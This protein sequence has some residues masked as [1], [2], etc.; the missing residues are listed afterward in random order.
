MLVRVIL[1]FRK[2]AIM[3]KKRKFGLGLSFIF[4]IGL[5]VGIILTSQLNTTTPLNATTANPEIKS[6]LDQ[7]S[8]LTSQQDDF[9]SQLNG[10][11]TRAAKKI[12]PS[13]VTIFSKKTIKTR[14][15]TNP[16]DL[17]EEFFRG[18]RRQQPN[19]QEFVRRGMGSGVIIDADGLILTNNHV[20][21]DAD[22]ISVK[23]TDGKIYDAEIIGTDPNT[24]LAVI[25]IDVT[26][27]PAASL[28]NSDQLEVGEW[29]LAVGNPFSEVLHQ[30]VTKGIVSAIGRQGLNLAAYE[31]FIQTDAPI[32][33]G[34]SGGALVNLYGELIGINTAI[35]APNGTFAG[36]GFAIPV[37][38]ARRIM[39]DLIDKG[40]VIR[41]YLGVEIQPVNADL[42][43]ALNLKNTKGALISSVEKDS[44][45]D[46]AGFKSSDVILKLN[47]VE[48][49][50]DDHLRFVVADV[51][52]GKRVQTI[53]NRNGKEKTLSIVIGERL[54]P[55][56]ESTPSVSSTIKGKLDIEVSNLTSELSGQYGYT[57]NSGVLITHVGTKIQSQR[58]DLRVGDL[59]KEVNR[60][61]VAIVSE[62]YEIIRNLEKGDRVLFLAQRGAN[63]FFEALE[64][65]ED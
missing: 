53:I 28:G 4:V 23:T 13:V 55:G 47:G 29:V 19:E 1:I 34:N 21:Q 62:F 54:E 27:L 65:N 56:Q 22:D 57:E 30:T 46:D 63:N 26:G 33:P 18:R 51:Q 45:A 32:N 6:I 8:E 60:K 43:K 40:R 39:K 7:N 31:D 41:G 42:A 15:Y 10:I 3:L 17:F 59:I 11:F 38:L 5:I 52:P 36:I 58:K 44:P 14:G 61:K 64:I 48:I 2:E 9:I 20:V 49:R 25:K 37:N 50:D 35:I 16:Y 12:K 24:D